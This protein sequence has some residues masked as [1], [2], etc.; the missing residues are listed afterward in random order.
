MFGIKIHCKRRNYWQRRNRKRREAARLVTRVLQKQM[1]GSIHH[2]SLFVGETT[3]Y[4][5]LSESGF[6]RAIVANKQ[7]FWGLSIQSHINQ[8]ERQ[9]TAPE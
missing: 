1:P 4:C 5:R 8:K 7:L 2:L 6:H 9:E 3:S